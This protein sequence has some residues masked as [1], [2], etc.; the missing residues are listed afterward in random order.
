MYSSKVIGTTKINY[1]LSPFLIQREEIILIKSKLKTTHIGNFSS[2]SKH[3]SSYS[4]PVQNMAWVRNL[5]PYW[6]SAED[7]RA[8][9]TVWDAEYQS[10]LVLS[11]LASNTWQVGL[12]RFWNG[13]ILLQ[14]GNLHCALLE[15]VTRLGAPLMRVHWMRVQP[16]A[17]LA[18]VGQQAAELERHWV[19]NSI[20][21]IF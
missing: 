5:G 13:L 14:S 9:S 8:R 16:K 20:V 18:T 17:C 10:S 11:C 21:E 12:T 3:H 7:L 4:C 19:K 1:L 6:F 15:N 2:S